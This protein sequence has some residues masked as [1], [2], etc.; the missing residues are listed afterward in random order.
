V[1]SLGTTKSW[2][3]PIHAGIN[4]Q[5]R[6]LDLTSGKPVPVLDEG[7]QLTAYWIGRDQQQYW[8]FDL[9]STQQCATNIVLKLPEYLYGGLGFRG[10]A[11]WNNKTKMAILTSEGVSDRIKAHTSRSRWIDISGEVG[12]KMAG[13]AILG[14]PSNFRAPQPLRV[15]P[16]E[17]FICFSPQQI[18]D[19][20][21]TPGKPYISRYRFIVHDGPPIRSRLDQFWD[22][23]ADPPR[24]EIIYPPT[25]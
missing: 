10:P 12:G 2:T 17:P 21:I 13:V 24:T 23:F 19:M 1:E 8:V 16:D 7:W 11:E 20:E 4:T 22:D 9:V 3:G 5:H 14:H 18:G 6:Y 25:F 15:H